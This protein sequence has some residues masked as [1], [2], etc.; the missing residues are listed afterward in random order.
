MKHNYVYTLED[1]VISFCSKKIIFKTA[2][3]EKEESGMRSLKCMQG[4]KFVVCT[5]Y[6]AILL[7]LVSKTFIILYVPKM[8]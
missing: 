5:T 7:Y 2:R 1:D 4:T 3:K 6:A 8:W